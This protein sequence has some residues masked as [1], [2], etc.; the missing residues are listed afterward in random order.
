MQPANKNPRGRYLEKIGYWLPRKT[1][2]VQRSIIL[3]KHKVQYW[4]GMGATCTN[5][6]HR[7]LE[8]YGLVPKTPVPFGASTLYEKPEKEYSMQ[9]YSKA[10]PKGNNRDLYLKQQLQEHMM[11]VEK[12]RRIQA[13][14]LANLGEHA[15]GQ[16][17][18]NLEEAKTEEIESEEVDI[19]ERKQKFDELLKR[20][21]KHRK[22][23]A[24]L[25]GND[26]RYNV[27]MR[28][29]NKL[30]RMDLGLDIE[31]YKDYVNNLK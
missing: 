19:F 1:V 15:A 31:S 14:A 6:V 29:L 25:R 13:E 23:K 3:N 20:I 26:L 5:R 27:Y 30:T 22:E 12:K 11:Q 18:Q 24:H 8:K 28:K 17:A 10:G 9:F 16:A 2:T 4:L 7:M 21:E